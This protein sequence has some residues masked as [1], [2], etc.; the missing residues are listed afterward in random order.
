MSKPL[1]QVIIA[2]VRPSRVGAK[3]A[4]WFLPIAESHGEFAV[5]RVDLKTFNLPI[6]DE[7]KHPR[8]GEYEHEHTK[9]WSASVAKAD[10]FVFVT[11]EYDFGPPASLIN[12]LQY[13]VKEW[14]YKPVGLLSYGGVSAGLRSANALRIMCT[15]NNMMPLPGAVSIPLVGQLVNKETGAFEPGDVQVKASNAMLTELARW[16]RA[17]RSLRKPA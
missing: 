4:D 6:M 5:E 16:E 7:P 14:S 12:A 1:L 15:A 11:P 17:M 3:V 2:S 9:R 10:A 8:L 13:L